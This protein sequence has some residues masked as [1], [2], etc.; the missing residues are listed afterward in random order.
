VNYKTDQELFWATEFGNKYISRNQNWII[1]VPFFSK[2]INRTTGLKSVIEF[3]CNIGLNLK[4]LD[5]L[6]P[7]VRLTG[8]EINKN[9][10]NYLERTGEVSVINSSIFDYDEGKKTY[11]MSMIKCVL[12]HINPTMLSDVYEKLYKS[13]NRYI[14]IS[15]YYNPSP[16]EVNYRGHNSRLF[17]RDFAGEM[18]DKYDNL[19]LLDYGFLYHRDNNFQ[20]DDINW[21]LLE[22]KIKE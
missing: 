6:L 22:K 7:E 10:C 1:N 16:V 12:I 18:M 11:D 8:V 17:K 4:A 19:I 20:Q 9:A 14:L 21:F 3:G 2:V 13:S 15:E 5:L